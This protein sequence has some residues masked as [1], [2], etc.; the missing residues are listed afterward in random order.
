MFNISADDLRWK[1]EAISF[2]T[3]KS[4]KFFDMDACS[5]IKEQLQREKAIEL[6]RLTKAAISSRSQMSKSGPSRGGRPGGFVKMGAGKKA[7][8]GTLRVGLASS[9]LTSG[10]GA[11]DKRGVAGP[12]KVTFKG[13]KNDEISKKQRAYR[14][15]YE[16]VSE[17]SEVLDDKIDEFAE[18]LRDQCKIAD[19]GDP[20]A[21]TEESTVIVGRICL[22]SESSSQ[23]V[24]LNEASLVIESSRMLASGARVQ[25]KFYPG[26][27]VR[28]GPAGVGGVQ[29]FPGAIVALKGKN[30]GGGCFMV[31]EVL[32]LPLL[33]YSPASLGTGVKP[34]PRDTAFSMFIASGPYTP[35]TDVKYAPFET[36]FQALL[37]KKPDV[38][39]LIGPFVDSAHPSIKDGDIDSSPADIFHDHFTTQLKDFLNLSPGSIVLL[40]PSIRDVIHN[41]VVFPQSEFQSE[42]AGDPRIHLLPNPSRFTLNDVSFGVTSVDT[43]F[44]LQKEKF[45]KAAAEVDAVSNGSSLGNDPMSNLCRHIIDQRS[46]YPLFP[47]PFDLSGDVNLDVTHMEGLRLGSDPESPQEYTPDVLILPS[48]LKQFSKVVDNTVVVNPSFLTK[49]FYSILDYQG[50]GASARRE[51]ISVSIVNNV[52]PT[53]P[54]QNP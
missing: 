27:K 42:Y 39:L 10:F 21:A 37:M 3:T 25:V 51:K 2:N 44:H 36:L 50:H 53:Q 41:H 14:F 46:F 48:R 5:T 15:M 1:W 29:W 43:L 35:D 19:L 31:E 23:N 20:A 6:A 49:G 54:T 9:R 47:V 11:D 45:F 24:K 17:R 32:T 28:G 18:L 16:K 4:I 8:D 7:L 38:V 22:D 13:P 52:P 30:G 26:V 33:P 40:V 12:S 34:E